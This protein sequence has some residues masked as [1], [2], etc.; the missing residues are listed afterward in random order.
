MKVLHKVEWRATAESPRPDV[1]FMPPLAQRRLSDVERA[2]LSVAWQAL[3]R[4]EAADDSVRRMIPVVFASRWGEIGTTVRLMQQMYADGEMSPA[5]FSNSVHNAAPGHLSLLLKNTAPYTAIAAGP[6]SYEM[7]L[8]EA[9]TYPGK[10][11]FIYAEEDTPAF[12]KPD[13][14]DVQSA[15]AVAMVIDN[16]G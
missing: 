10:V 1:S 16:E 3:E 11:L 4:Y 9:S 15:H 14:E 7:G 6:D 12:Y 8:L 5:G 13:F 2:A